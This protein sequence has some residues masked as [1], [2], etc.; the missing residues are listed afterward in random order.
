MCVRP[1]RYAPAPVVWIRSA[2]RTPS[3]TMAARSAR[4]LAWSW[5]FRWVHVA[6]DNIVLFSVL[7]ER[8]M[9]ERGNGNRLPGVVSNQTS[10]K[11]IVVDVPDYC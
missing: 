9:D 5:V 6:L 3:N 10:E 8:G 4:L 1:R 7:Q 11:R 2:R